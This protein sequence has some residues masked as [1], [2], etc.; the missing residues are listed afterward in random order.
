MAAYGED[1]VWL[2]SF[3][4]STLGEMSGT[5]QRALHMES[6]AVWWPQLFWALWRIGRSLALLVI[7][8]GANL[9]LD[10]LGSCLGR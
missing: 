9:G 8:P 6:E 4:T 2:H 3:L 10:R 1:E 7:K 5:V